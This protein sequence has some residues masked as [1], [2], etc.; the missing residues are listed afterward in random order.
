MMNEEERDELEKVARDFV[1]EVSQDREYAD[2]VRLTPHHYEVAGFAIRL[3]NKATLG[4]ADSIRCAYHYGLEPQN[5]DAGR[6]L[7]DAV[8]KAQ[9]IIVG[10]NDL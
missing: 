2:S 1:Y 7:S 10:D 6:Y 9:D 5:A 3:R 8:D 4:L